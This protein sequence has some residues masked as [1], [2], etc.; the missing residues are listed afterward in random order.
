[1]NHCSFRVVADLN[2][3]PVACSVCLTRLQPEALKIGLQHTWAEK[4]Y[5]IVIRPHQ[6][7]G[8]EAAYRQMAALIGQKL[9]VV[10]TD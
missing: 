8:L 7:N 10:T 9:G 5:Q 1:V 2:P 3:E 4:T 6:P